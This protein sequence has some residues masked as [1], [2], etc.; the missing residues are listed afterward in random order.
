MEHLEYALLKNTHTPRPTPGRKIRKQRW[1]AT[2][3]TTTRTTRTTTE[4]EGASVSAQAHTHSRWRQILHWPSCTW[5]RS[6][7]TALAPTVFFYPAVER[8]DERKCVRKRARASEQPGRRGE[9][10]MLRNV[11]RG[12]WEPE[13]QCACAAFSI[14]KT[15]PRVYALFLRSSVMC[16]MFLVFFCNRRVN[17][18]LRKT[19]P[20][21]GRLRM[22]KNINFITKHA[23][24]WHLWNAVGM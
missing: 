17:L 11:G 5:H 23:P 24:I 21:L 19:K 1:T 7:G 8:F 13:F 20:Q 12:R 4:R 22:I 16:A 6:Y 9:Q 14:Y 15:W 3:V 10:W 2:D 18:A